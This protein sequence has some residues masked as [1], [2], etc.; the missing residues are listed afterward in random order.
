MEVKTITIKYFSM[1][2]ENAVTINVIT[3]IV[4]EMFDKVKK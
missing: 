1:F 2:S 3:A 4:D